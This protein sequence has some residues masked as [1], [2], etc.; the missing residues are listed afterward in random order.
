MY[1]VFSGDRCVIISSSGV[2]N[3]GTE[4]RTVAFESAEQLHREYLQFSRSAGPQNLVITGDEEKIWRVFRSLFSYVEAAGGLVFNPAHELLMIYR[5]KHW[6]LPKGKME[7]GEEP[8]QTAMREVEEECG[9][10]KLRVER[11]LGSTY[12]IFFQSGT[13]CLKR[14]HWFEMSCTDS[15]G[16]IPQ[17]EEG[18]EEAKWMSKSEAK[19]ILDSVYLSLRE[20]LATFVV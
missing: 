13:G 15:S 5:N 11:L 17:A 20:V 10:K 14:T 7:A 19:N 1:K 18:I 3:S 4:S 9:I 16:L 12:H 2:K 8:E 6:D